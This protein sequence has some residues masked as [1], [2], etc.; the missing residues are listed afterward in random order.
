MD[1]LNILHSGGSPRPHEVNGVTALVWAL[2]T[3]QAARGD[4]VALQL[5]GE[6]DAEAKAFASERGIELTARWPDTKPDIVHCHS[7]FIPAQIGLCL[8]ARRKRIPFVITPHGGLAREILNRGRLKKALY[9]TFIER[10]RFY[11]AA[12]IVGVAPRE[13]DQIASFVPGYRGRVAVIPNVV[14]VARL[15]FKHW[16]RQE[17]R[18]RR[19]LVYLGRFDVD[20]KGID[21]LA[22]VAAAL[23]ETDVH[24]YGLGSSKAVADLQTRRPCNLHFHAPVY[25]EDKIK[26]LLDAD[27]YV[28]MSRWEAFGISVA[29]AMSLGVP[30][31]IT[32]T[33]NL[34]PI[35]TEQRLG[36]TIPLDPVI[37]AAKI[38]AALC[39][40]AALGSWSASARRYAL[41]AFA[42]DTVVDAYARFYRDVAT[43]EARSGSRC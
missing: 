43:V 26:V 20:H 9:S 25:D 8:M 5:S 35:F 6:P 36:L 27:M 37:A 29:E 14:E 32:E 22:A 33:M 38:R 16:Q 40:T 17:H 28:Q 11:G 10:P 19:K 4:K 31:A 41:H 1:T 34:A 30:C 2:A 24:L 21:L 13:R 3:G 39:N 18:D 7:V 15:S 23:T 12:G 42:P